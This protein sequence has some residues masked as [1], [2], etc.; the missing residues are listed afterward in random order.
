MSDIRGQR[1]ARTGDPVRDVSK[2][3]KYYRHNSDPLKEALTGR[4]YHEPHWAL[5][6]VTFDVP[7]GN[8]VGVIGPNGAGSTLLRIITGLLD[9]TSGGVRVKGRISAI[10]E[11]GTGFHPDFTGRQNIITGGLCLGMSRDEIEARSSWIID[12]SE[13]GRVIDQ[14]FR[15]YSSGM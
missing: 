10:L 2:A 14:P 6:N 5:R 15:T 3:Y 13:L 11:L 8:I 12:F 7:K 9:P 4:R 1:E